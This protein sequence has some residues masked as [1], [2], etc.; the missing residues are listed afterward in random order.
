MVFD[1]QGEL[2]KSVP[3]AEIR[4][5][6]L[7]LNGLSVPVSKRSGQKRCALRGRRAEGGLNGRVQRLLRE[8]ASDFGSII[9]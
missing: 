7:Y 9:R 1:L 2:H 6:D 4:G 5:Q 3:I 8:P